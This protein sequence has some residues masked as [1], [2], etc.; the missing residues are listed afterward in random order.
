MNGEDCIRTKKRLG[1]LSAEAAFEA[2]SDGETLWAPCVGTEYRLNDYGDVLGRVRSPDGTW[3]EWTVRD[4]MNTILVR[5]P[6]VP[7]P[8]CAT[9]RRT[10]QAAGSPEYSY[11][12]EHEDGM[13]YVEAV[14]CDVYRGPHRALDAC[15]WYVKDDRKE[16]E[17]KESRKRMKEAR[18]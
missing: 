12:R 10:V 2:L 13:P 3:S 9:C 7:A 5:R 8:L 4:C 18:I 16:K 1:A 15:D 14:T 17:S 11:G 6:E